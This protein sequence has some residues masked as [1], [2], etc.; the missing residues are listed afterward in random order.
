V[1]PKKAA[2]KPAPEKKAASKPTPKKKAAKEAPKKKDK[3]KIKWDPDM[4]KDELYQIAK[5]A[6]LDVRARDWKEEII[7]ELKKASK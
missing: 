6:G 1:K 3:P 2:P 4:T 7:A 5:K